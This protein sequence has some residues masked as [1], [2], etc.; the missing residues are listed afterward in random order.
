MSNLS[1]ELWKNENNADISIYSIY[2]YIYIYQNL[3]KT[4]EEL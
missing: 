3:M 2:I 1:S 4:F